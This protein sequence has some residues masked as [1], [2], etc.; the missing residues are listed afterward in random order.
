MGLSLSSLSLL[1]SDFIIEFLCLTLTSLFSNFWCFLVFA[2]P[3][4]LH[5]SFLHMD[6]VFPERVRTVSWIILDASSSVSFSPSSDILF[7]D[8]IFRIAD[9]HQVI[10]KSFV[11][12]HFTDAILF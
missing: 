10:I 3:M 2:S 8:K 9:A 5:H 11:R 6:V 1:G 4:I 7:S 12:P